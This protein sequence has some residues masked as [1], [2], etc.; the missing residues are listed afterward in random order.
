MLSVFNN[1]ILI[2]FGTTLPSQRIDAGNYFPISFTPKAVITTAQEYINQDSSYI[3]I[4]SVSI[5]Y[6]QWWVTNYCEAKLHW[7]AIGY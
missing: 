5:N 2:Q 4:A 3:E 7:I 6:F 1:R